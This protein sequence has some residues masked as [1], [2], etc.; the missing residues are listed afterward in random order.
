LAEHPSGLLA[1][2]KPVGIRT[3][4][5]DAKPDPRALLRAAYDTEQEAYRWTDSDGHPH[6]LFLLNRLDAP[7]SGILL[8]CQNEACLGPA[9]AAFEDGKVTKRYFAL[10]AGLP[11]HRQTVWQDRLVRERGPHGNWTVRIARPGE[12][13]PGA[14]AVTHVNALALDRHG[15][16]I[17]L[18]ELLPATGRTHQLRVQCAAR[19]LPV[20]GDSTYG[21]FRRNR[22]LARRTRCSDRLMLHAA[23]L[24]I[25]LDTPGFAPFQAHSAL[26]QEFAKALGG[27][28]PHLGTFPPSQP[29]AKIPPKNRRSHHR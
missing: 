14:D 26:P 8:A 22:E 15:L 24:L 9:R 7:T 1:F 3:H 5:N 17:T 27:L 2:D 29:S 10:V 20:L 13:T 23:D 19:R 25:T 28:P 6:T 12:K 4:P 11:A 16:G 21:D 18:L